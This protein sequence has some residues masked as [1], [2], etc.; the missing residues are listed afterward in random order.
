MEVDVAR[1]SFSLIFR[2]L[3]HSAGVNHNSGKC[4]TELVARGPLGQRQLANG[5]PNRLD[6]K[7]VDVVP[8]ER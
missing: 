1:M 4:S 6:R 8:A 5:R 3:D 7:L 2:G